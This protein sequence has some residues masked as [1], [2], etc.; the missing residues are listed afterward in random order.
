[1][2]NIKITLYIVLILL[3]IKLKILKLQ[4]KLSEKLNALF[5]I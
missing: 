4:K 1:M 3:Y 2:N 5:L